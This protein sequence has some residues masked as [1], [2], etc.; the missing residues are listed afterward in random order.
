MINTTTFTNWSAMTPGAPFNR[1]SPNLIALQEYLLKRWGGMGLGIYGV[2][3]TRDNPGQWSVHAFGAALDFRY[4][5]PGPGRAVLLDD[6][7]PFLIENSAE[8]GVQAVHDYAGGRIWRSNRGDGKGAY[9]KDQPRSSTGMGQ[10]WALWI[11]IEV[12]QAAWGDGRPVEQRLQGVTVPAPTLRRGMQSP[13]VLALTQYLRFFKITTAEPGPTFT[14]AVERSVKRLQR[15]LN[16]LPD[17]VYGPGTANAFK[18]W[19][20]RQ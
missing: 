13:D 3:G 11:H 6:I 18:Q 1:S 5:S 12:H 17:G 2:R 19:I 10:T 9:W 14:R 16:V 20:E 4:Q 8:L 15:R 7:I